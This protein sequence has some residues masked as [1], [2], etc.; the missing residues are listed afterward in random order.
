MSLAR[1]WAVCM[2]VAASSPLVL[3][4]DSLC[5][6]FWT[7]FCCLFS[8]LIDL[9]GFWWSSVFLLW[10]CCCIFWMFFCGRFLYLIDSD[11]F[12]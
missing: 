11:G 6:V 9:V 2:G 5:W 7:F 4:W 8:C 1:G 12:W 10:D 3:V